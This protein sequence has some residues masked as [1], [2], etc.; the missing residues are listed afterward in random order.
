MAEVRIDPIL[1]EILRHKLWQITEEMAIAIRKVSGSTI[2][3]EARDLSTNLYDAQGTMIMCGSGII[4][5]AS[6]MPFAIKHVLETYSEEPGIYDGDVFFLN[7]PYI[8]AMHQPDGTV[9]TPIFYKGELIGWS[10]TMTHLADIGGI[11]ASR[12]SSLLARARISSGNLISAIRSRSSLTS[13]I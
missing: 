9:M 8:S 12:S 13:C 4:T 1:F 6:T 3:C 7:D 2:T 10:Q 11:D 5:H